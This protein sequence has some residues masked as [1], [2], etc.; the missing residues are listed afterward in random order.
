MLQVGNDIEACAGTHC[1]HTGPVGPIKILKSERVQDGVERIE[2][3]AGEA[4]VRAIQHAESLLDSSSDILK[5]APEH[6]PSTIKRFFVE[7]K[8]LK[9]ENEKLKEELARARVHQ[10]ME[11][12]IDIGEIRMIPCSIPNADSDELT[13]IAGEL[14]EQTDMVALLVSDMD[15]V[16]IVAAAGDDA[17]SK[18]VDVGKI[19]KDMSNT[20]GGGGGGRPNMARG[21]GSDPSR[22][23]KA[24]N[25][26]QQMLK[27]QIRT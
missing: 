20:V 14:A 3:A 11:D 17:V 5:V 2:Y 19:V 15:G 9:K 26:G 12:A 4:A 1:T 16:K 27:E 10:L 6:L 24:L 22:I 7:W 25:T 8:A 21:G 18:G 13:K 23:Q